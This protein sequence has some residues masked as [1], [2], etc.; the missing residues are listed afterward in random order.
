[1]LKKIKKV[2]SILTDILLVGRNRGWWSR[3]NGPPKMKDPRE[4]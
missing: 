1:M 4:R 2:L 3:K